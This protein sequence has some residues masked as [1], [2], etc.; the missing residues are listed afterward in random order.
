M[1]GTKGTMRLK[2]PR[3]GE[4][5]DDVSATIPLSPR[6]SALT[7]AVSRAL[8]NIG[9]V[10][11]RIGRFQQAINTYVQLSRTGIGG[12]SDPGHGSSA[13][14]SHCSS[15]WEIFTPEPFAIKSVIES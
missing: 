15:T 8:D 7:D 14:C 2:K 10:Y 11:A 1:G 6:C 4:E 3:V 12:W 9:H 5:Q 13:V